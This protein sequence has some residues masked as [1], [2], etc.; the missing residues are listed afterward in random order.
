MVFAEYRAEQLVQAP[1]LDRVARNGV[2]VDRRQSTVQLAATTRLAL[3]LDRWISESNVDS[4][5]HR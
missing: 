2:I 4:L 5:V 3:V 1:L